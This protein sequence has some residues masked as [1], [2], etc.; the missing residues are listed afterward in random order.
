MAIRDKEDPTTITVSMLFW[1][2]VWGICPLVNTVGVVVGLV[3]I[4]YSVKDVVLFK[5]RS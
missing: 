5:S 2:I 4:A 3:L 1:A